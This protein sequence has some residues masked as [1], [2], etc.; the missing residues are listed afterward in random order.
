[1]GQW[2]LFRD[3]TVILIKLPKINGQMTKITFKYAKI[4]Q[5]GT[6]YPLFVVVYEI[7]N[8]IVILGYKSKK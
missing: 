8:Y 4:A 1:M 7:G 3:K 5:N 2:W 6:I